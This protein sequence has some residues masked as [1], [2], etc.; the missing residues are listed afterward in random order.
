MFAEAELARNAFT[1]HLNQ[2][3]FSRDASVR[4]G[5]RMVPP[6][7]GC[8]IARDGIVRCAGRH[9]RACCIQ[10][11]KTPQCGLE[12]CSASAAAGSPTPELRIQAFDRQR[13]GSTN[14][15]AV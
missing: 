2:T 8:Q 3:F 15:S 10:S 1:I 4:A 9:R 12:P 6:R 14:V 7:G 11:L 5:P 13:M